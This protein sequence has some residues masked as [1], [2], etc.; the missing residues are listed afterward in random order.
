[1]QITD[2]SKNVIKSG[3][4]WI[5]SIELETIAMAHP[6]ASQ[7]ACIAAKHAKWDECPLLIVVRK[8]QATLT[9]EELLAFYDGKIAKWWTP[10]EVI[11]V[12][13][14]ALGATGKVQKNRLREQSG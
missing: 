7:A 1:M 8:P 5:G 4:E 3:G 12:D 10:D 11:F 6:A 2:R 14:I 9:R 13:T